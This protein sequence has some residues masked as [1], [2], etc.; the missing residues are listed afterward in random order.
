MFTFFLI[1]IDINVYCI[2]THYVVIRH[3]LTFVASSQ[4]VSLVNDIGTDVILCIM[5]VL[6]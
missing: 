4:R 1:L 5:V 6:V 3:V 2:I